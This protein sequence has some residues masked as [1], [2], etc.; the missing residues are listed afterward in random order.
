MRHC[1]ELGYEETDIDLVLPGGQLIQLQYRLCSPSL[2]VCLPE[3]TSVTNWG[4]D[5]EPSPPA[6]RGNEEHVRLASQVV[7]DL[8][9]E[10]VEK[11]T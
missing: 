8:N 6:G 1:I 4:D 7:I 9:P 2:E 10:W 11:R 5:M 3:P